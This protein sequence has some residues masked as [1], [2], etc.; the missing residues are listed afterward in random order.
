MNTITPQE[1]DPK[2]HSTTDG[3]LIDVRTPAEYTGEHATGAVNYPL[4]ELDPKTLATRAGS[5]PIYVLC[6]SGTRAREAIQQL[7]SAGIDNT[8]LVEG[9]TS[10]WI[11]AGLP[12][13]QGRKTISL[14]R[15]VRIAA[16]SL[17]ALGAILGLTGHPNWVFLSGFVGAGLVFAGASGWCGM[18]ELLGFKPW[19]RVF[20]SPPLEQSTRSA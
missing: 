6:Q 19:N 20:R 8:I 7:E 4:S 13:V 10:A 12:T 18:A 14:E 17:V 16:G 1:L 5:K 9:G 15:Q 11:E 2:T 3:L